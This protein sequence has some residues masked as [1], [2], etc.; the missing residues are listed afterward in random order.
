MC[1]AREIEEYLQGIFV[2]KKKKTKQQK[3]QKNC[4]LEGEKP[5]TSRERP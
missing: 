2:V 4:S 5:F 3:K 1:N